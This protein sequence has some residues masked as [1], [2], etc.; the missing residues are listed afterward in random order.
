MQP[1]SMKKHDVLLAT[2][3]VKVIKEREE[4]YHIRA[5]LHQGSEISLVSEN[6]IQRLHISRQPSSIPIIGIGEQKSSKTRGSV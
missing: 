5:L 3:Q 2:A 4:K 6:L 1:S